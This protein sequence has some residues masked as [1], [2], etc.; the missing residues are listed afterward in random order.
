M[1]YFESIIKTTLE[2]EGYWVRQS[3]K[4]NVTKEE[5]RQIGKHTIPR[6]EVDILAY[7]PSDNNLLVIEVK[8]Y[9]DNPGVRLSDLQKEHEKPEGGYKLFTCENYRNIVFNRLKK[10]LIEIGMVNQDT[11][12]SLGLA[13]GN[14]FQNKS[15]E[16]N[17]FF[18]SKKWVFISPEDIKEKVTNLA[19]MGYENEPAVITAKILTRK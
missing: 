11:N 17:E 4:I 12:I 8:S 5:K 18:I 10:D 15:K 14:V 2:Y 3:F 19:S 7:K 1:D 9:F 16:I 13:A 6:P